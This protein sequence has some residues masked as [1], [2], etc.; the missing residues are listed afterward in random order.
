M[1]A[2]PWLFLFASLAFAIVSV[3][4]WIRAV[5]PIGFEKRMDATISAIVAALFVGAAALCLTA[6]RMVEAS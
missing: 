5:K 3:T 6:V 2:V 4:I 1:N